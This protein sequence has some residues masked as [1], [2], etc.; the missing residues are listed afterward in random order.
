MDQFVDIFSSYHVLEVRHQAIE[1][2]SRMLRDGIIEE[3][4][5]LWSS[6]IVVVPK[7]NGSMRLCN[8]FQRLKQVSDFD[9]YSLL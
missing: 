4:A 6:P 2:V 8:D 3:S 7:P 5:S 9:S 1:E